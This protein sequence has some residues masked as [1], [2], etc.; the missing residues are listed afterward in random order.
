ML[1][2]PVANVLDLAFPGPRRPQSCLRTGCG[3]G[4]QAEFR[5]RKKRSQVLLGTLYLRLLAVSSVSSP[6]DAETLLTHPAHFYSEP[7]SFGSIWITAF[8]LASR[9][10]DPH[11]GD[12]T[13]R[14][15][16]IPYSLVRAH[17]LLNR[18]RVR[19]EGLE[20]IGTHASSQRKP[21]HTRR[22]WN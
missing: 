3:R 14:P 7:P 12:Q 22:N 10:G 11:T 1:P 5:R 9:F 16:R 4:S 18:P 8:D 21:D 15:F 2:L 17:W 19:L 6:D 13:Y 20:G